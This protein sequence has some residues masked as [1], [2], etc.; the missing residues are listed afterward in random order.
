[1]FCKSTW[2]AIQFESR[3]DGRDGGDD[4]SVWH[5]GPVHVDLLGG[6]ERG[7]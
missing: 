2:T 7:A 4:G 5:D 3:L 1:M 6:G